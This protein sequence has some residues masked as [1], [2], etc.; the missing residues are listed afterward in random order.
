LLRHLFQDHLTKQWN[1]PCYAPVQSA[2]HLAIQ[3]ICQCRQ[4]QPDLQAPLNTIFKLYLYGVI[5]YRIYSGYFHNSK[6]S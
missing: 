4:V 6:V 2:F 3:R 1:N 5:A